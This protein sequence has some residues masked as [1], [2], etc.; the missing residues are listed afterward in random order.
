MYY[1][2]ITH[3]GYS[4]TLKKCRKY[5]PATRVF[6]ISF[7]FSNACHVLSQFNT[8]L[9]LFICYKIKIVNLLNMFCFVAV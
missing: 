5:S 7:V 2:V 8:W 3:S 6:Y 4:R 1:T 9:T